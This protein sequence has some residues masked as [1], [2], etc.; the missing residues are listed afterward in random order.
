MYGHQ[1][2]DDLSINICKWC[3]SREPM[4]Q[5]LYM[6]QMRQCCEEICNNCKKQCFYG[7]TKSVKVSELASHPVKTREDVNPIMVNICQHCNWQNTRE[8]VYD[9][10][11]YVAYCCKNCAMSSYQDIFHDVKLSDIGSYPPLTREAVNQLKPLKMKPKTINLCKY[12]DGQNTVIGP[13]QN[14]VIGPGQNTESETK[15]NILYKCIKCGH[16]SENNDMT[17]NVKVL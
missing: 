8:K 5:I 9:D 1:K 10:Y 13:G 14:T 2:M 11:D 6:V 12:C 15:L 17:I 3:N 4:T 16:K 7:M